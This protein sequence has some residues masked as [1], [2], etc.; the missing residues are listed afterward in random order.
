MSPDVGCSRGPGHL[1][2]KRLRQEACGADPWD[3]PVLRALFKASMQLVR[4]FRAVDLGEH[5]TFTCVLTVTQ[6][7]HAESLP[8]PAMPPCG[9]SW[10][11]GRARLARMSSRGV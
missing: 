6:K 1:H 8:P 4:R 10:R 11:P 2:R 7:G 9:R 5:L 3:K